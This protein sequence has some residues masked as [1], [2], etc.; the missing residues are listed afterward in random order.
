MIEENVN[1]K[2]WFGI[3]FISFPND[4]LSL[5]IG[6]KILIISNFNEIEKKI[7]NFIESQE[8]EDSN[9]GDIYNKSFINDS[10]L[11][12]NFNCEEYISGEENIIDSNDNEDNRIAQQYDN[13]LNERFIFKNKMEKFLDLIIESHN[14][15]LKFEK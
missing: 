1:L 14:V 9:E 12:S 8:E 13:T 7:P 4:D 6:D 11:K 15:L 10:C 3:T 2:D 5:S